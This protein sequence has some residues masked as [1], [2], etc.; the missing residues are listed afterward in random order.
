M[1]LRTYSISTSMCFGNIWLRTS[2]WS[3]NR[4]YSLNYTLSIDSSIHVRDFGGAVRQSFIWSVY[5]S[6]HW[7]T[8]V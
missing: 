3:M 4:G 5:R 6:R 2:S 1:I 8:G 7:R